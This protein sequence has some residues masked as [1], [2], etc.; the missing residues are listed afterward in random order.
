MFSSLIYMIS[1][2]ERMEQTTV[3]SIQWRRLEGTT[4][5]RLL[6]SYGIQQEWLKIYFLAKCGCLREGN[7]SFSTFKRQPGMHYFRA[8]V[9]RVL[10]SL[11]QLH[12]EQDWAVR[13]R[14]GRY[15]WSF[16]IKPIT[17]SHWRITTIYWISWYKA[18][19]SD[20]RQHRRYSC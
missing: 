12:R 4:W 1:H 19:S 11:A 16:T 9:T 14:W 15:D 3:K 6:C 18:W 10:W 17:C 8:Q 20:Q 7:K 13:T 5:T 2:T